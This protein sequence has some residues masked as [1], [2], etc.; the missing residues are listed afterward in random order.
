[1]AADTKRQIEGRMAYE[2]TQLDPKLGENDV[3]YPGKS[4]VV[5]TQGVR[6]CVL[7]L[8]RVDN[9]FDRKAIRDL[10]VHVRKG[11]KNPETPV[12]VLRTGVGAYD[13]D[14]SHNSYYFNAGMDLN[15]LRQLSEISPV[16]CVRALQQHFG[17]AA[18][19]ALCRTPVAAI[20]S[21]RSSMG[22]L[23]GARWRVATEN[24]TIASPNGGYGFI[25]DPG[26][27]YTLGRM[28][29]Y[30]GLY[31][32]L[33]GFPLTPADGYY[34]GLVTHAMPTDA[35]KPL[36]TMLNQLACNELTYLDV[37]LM[38]H[39]KY[40]VMTKY[41][42][43]AMDRKRDLLD[44]GLLRSAA[45]A[46]KM[47]DALFGWTTLE[48][49]KAETYDDYWESNV[50]PL[51]NGA[52]Q[53]EFQSTPPPKE[54]AAPSERDEILA[55]ERAVLEMT[56]PHVAEEAIRKQGINYSMS[57]IS[58]FGRRRVRE[59]LETFC[60]QPTEIFGASFL[61][62]NQE[63]IDRIFSLPTV[64]KVVSA[65]R[66]EEH[67]SPFAQQTLQA[68]SKTPP[69]LLKLNFRLYKT[70]MRMDRFNCMKLEFRLMQR[71]LKS[72]DF[73]HGVKLFPR[74]DGPRPRWEVSRLEDVSDQS[75]DDMFAPRED[76]YL[77]DLRPE[78]LFNSPDREFVFQW[79]FPLWEGAGRKEVTHY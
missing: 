55:R 64:E 27:S 25:C 50:A 79:D 11:E 12:V 9:V 14:F 38:D 24:G 60:V 16:G 4:I 73:T 78:P 69:A 30:S 63:N 26:A 46:D 37:D 61:E 77:L 74:G 31:A 7:T 53:P 19:L 8:D 10:H 68:F 35:I 49:I 15:E 29:G 75:I 76:D 28:P 23:D 1:M 6:S 39:Q 66:A 40:N 22:L 48:K 71:L 5:K 51:A 36:E 44:A 59:I 47:S 54:W 21:G 20:I 62:Q 13:G 56:A 33:T 72:H 67:Y 18:M 41:M 34:A 32:G 3:M 45:Q 57:E 52:A 17:F 58:G 65:L 70:A 42:N 2:L 43:S